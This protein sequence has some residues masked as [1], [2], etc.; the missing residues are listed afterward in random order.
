MFRPRCLLFHACGHRHDD[1]RDNVG[2]PDSRLD[3]RYLSTQ[4]A[5]TEKVSEQE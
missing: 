5:Q 1:R 2:T 3:D 4:D